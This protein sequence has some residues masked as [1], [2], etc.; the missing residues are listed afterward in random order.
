MWRVRPVIAGV[1]MCATPAGIGP[2]PDLRH[3]PTPETGFIS[4]LADLSVTPRWATWPFSFPRWGWWQESPSLLLVAGRSF[5]VLW[6]EVPLQAFYWS[7]AA[8]NYYFQHAV[9]RVIHRVHPQDAR[10]YPKVFKWTFFTPKLFRFLVETA[11]SQGKE[12]KIPHIIQIPWLTGPTVAACRSSR[13]LSAASK[14]DDNKMMTSTCVFVLFYRFWLN[15]G[16][17]G[18]A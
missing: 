2:S 16:F 1:L 15:W 7:R 4:P 13:S 9:Q 12:S 3:R 14:L 5:W 6:H 8:S 17:V 11:F 10:K 18:M